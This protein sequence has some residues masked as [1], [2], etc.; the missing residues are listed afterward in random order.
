MNRTQIAPLIL[1]T[2]GLAGAPAA[3]AEEPRQVRL[4]VLSGQSNMA[5]LNPDVSFTPAVKAAFPN[6]DVIVV[7][8]AQGGQPIRRWHK[9][10]KAPDGTTVKTAGKNGD[11]YEVL[12]A[13]VKKALGGK[14]PDSVSFVWMQGERDAKEGLSA[15]YSD[16]L[17]GLVRQLETD[18]GR[19]DMTV[20]VGRLSDCDPRGAHWKAV[21]EAQVAFAD[22]EPRAAWVDTDDLNGPRDNLHYTKEGYAELGRRFAA[23]TVHLLKKPVRKD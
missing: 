16:S 14:K 5:G 11:L 13:A 4:F 15:V 6:D 20:V 8:S 10:W 19:K 22:R 7:K 2:W 23:E 21:R 1:I 12:L 3:S 9:D 18:L 17:R